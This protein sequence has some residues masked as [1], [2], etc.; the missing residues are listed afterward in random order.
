M[1]SDGMYAVYVSLDGPLMN[2]LFDRVIHVGDKLEVWGASNGTQNAA[3]PLELTPSAVLLNVGFNGVTILHDEDSNAQALGALDISPTNFPSVSIRRINPLGGVVPSV[4]GVVTRV[5]PSHYQ[6]TVQQA[7]PL[8]KKSDPNS[9]YR[10]PKITRN[11]LA[12]EKHIEKMTTKKESEYERRLSCR[13]STSNNQ[14]GGGVDVSVLEEVGQEVNSSFSRDVS[15]VTTIVVEDENGDVAVVQQWLR[16]GS[17]GEGGPL[18]PKEGSRVRLFNLHPGRSLRP[19]AP[20]HGK[21]LYARPTFNFVEAPLDVAVSEEEKQMF[22]FER[23]VH[24]A[25]EPFEGS[26]RDIMVDICCIAI[27]TK[28]VPAQTVNQTLHSFIFC[29][30]GANIYGSLEIRSSPHFEI[31]LNGPPRG[32]PCIIQNCMFSAFDS[33]SGPHN[34]VRFHANEYT[35]IVVRTGE[36]V[37]KRH[38]LEMEARKAGLERT[39]ATGEQLLAHSS[40]LHGERDDESEEEASASMSF[41]LGGASEESSFLLRAPVAG[42]TSPR[43]YTSMH[44][45]DTHNN[46]AILQDA[47]PGSVRGPTYLTSSARAS[48]TNGRSTITPTKSLFDGSA[49]N[50]TFSLYN[51]EDPPASSAVSVNSGAS[52]PT[53][54][55]GRQTASPNNGSSAP[56]TTLINRGSTRPSISSANRESGKI[57]LA[58]VAEGGA[59]VMPPAGLEEVELSASCVGRSTTSLP[60]CANDDS[61]SEAK[62]STTVV[63]E[64][65]ENDPKNEQPEAQNDHH[66]VPET[67]EAIPRALRQMKHR[68]QFAESLPAKLHLFCNLIPESLSLT[69]SCGPCAQIHHRII[70]DQAA[71]QSS[72]ALRAR[73][74]AEAGDATVTA[75][76]S[77]YGLHKSDVMTH[78]ISVVLTGMLDDGAGVDRAI[79]FICEGADLAASLLMELVG[80]FTPLAASVVD[81]GW[82]QLSLARSKVLHQ[83]DTELQRWKAYILQSV[84]VDSGMLSL[85][86]D[87]ACSRTQEEGAGTSQRSNDGTAP[88]IRFDELAKVPHWNHALVG[89]CSNLLWWYTD[90]WASLQRL[91]HGAISMKLVNVTLTNITSADSDPNVPLPLIN[92]VTIREQLPIGLLAPFE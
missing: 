57:A 36:E 46:A 76:D 70:S 11:Q 68:M 82:F 48:Q 6:E 12:E 69:I 13:M 4:I 9:A 61:E 35:K 51:V 31:F 45:E 71:H 90:E 88:V 67:V 53:Y 64:E 22:S 83:T 42:G 75:E 63:A 18:V 34:V 25:L 77:F 80:A 44:S 26:M 56:V 37:L 21:M 27:D 5:L 65:A 52:S 10:A 43:L 60:R 72:M 91:I 81:D 8:G 66:G 92:C 30:S 55:N 23:K 15:E 85:Y 19:V 89:D 86:S 59:T 17:H 16:G 78:G 74:T 39:I 33:T 87:D 7:I 58:G 40:A 38:L 41:S 62:P 2:A 79:P 50:P 32:T 14:E 20:F 29:A 54:N 73:R 49:T 3:H 28:P 24:T 1:V 84:V 47:A